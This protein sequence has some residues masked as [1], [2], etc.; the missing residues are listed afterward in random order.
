MGKATKTKTRKKRVSQIGYHAP[1]REAE[2][3]G[4]YIRAGIAYR[5]V[6][7]IDTML[8][9]GQITT[10]EHASLGYYRDQ[11]S[12]AERSPVRSCLNRDVISGDGGHIS[13]AVQSA[14]LQVARIE[15]DLGS[16]RDIAR[17]VAVDDTSLSQWC[18][19]Q[20]GGRERYDGK[21]KFIALVPVRERENM[22]LA[23]M[24]IKMAAHRI[25]S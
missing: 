10:A 23:I 15:R 13:I 3:H 7:M 11:A 1:T 4:S 25:V 18:I 6:P 20:N 17:A 22:R 19:D 16:L 9:R 8:S 21:G 5:R 24:M 12:I 14:I 2:T